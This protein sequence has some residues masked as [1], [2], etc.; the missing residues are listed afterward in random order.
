MK[1]YTWEEVRKVLIKELK[2]TK[3]I[4]T[5]G[6]IGSCNV[7]HDIDT[8]ITKKPY[9]TTEEF[10]KEIHELFDSLEKYLY[11]KYGGKVLVF[12]KH[13][14]EFLTISEYKKKKDLVIQAMIYTSY[15]QIE[16]DWGWFLFKKDSIKRV[17]KEYK[18]LKGIKED[19]KNKD[20][21]KSLFT[22]PILIY[23]YPCDRIHAH[24]PKKDLI[25]IM[26]AYYDFFFRKWMKKEKPKTNNLDDVKNNFYLLCKTIDNFEK[27]K[28]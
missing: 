26:D 14:E 18:L 16:K 23:L 25:R 22:D 5:Y 11:Q 20:F 2:K 19:L 7:D 24:Y 3:H 1:P 27:E 12:P 8:I 28:H 9:S 17:L 13:E 10:Y 4:L 21:K 6:T 15:S